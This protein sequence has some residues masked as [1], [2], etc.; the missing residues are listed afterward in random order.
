MTLATSQSYKG[1]ESSGVTLVVF[2][3]L[4]L[5]TFFSI[6]LLKIIG[7]K[8]LRPLVTKSLLKSLNKLIGIVFIVFGL[9]LLFK[10]F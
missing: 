3:T 5:V 4:I 8:Y 7:A 10:L 6:D 2:I 9:Y 1:L